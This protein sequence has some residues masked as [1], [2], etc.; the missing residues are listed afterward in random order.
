VIR[1]PVF[2]LALDVVGSA[3]KAGKGGKEQEDLVECVTDVVVQ[4][5]LAFFGEPTGEKVITVS[6]AGL[7]AIGAG[8]WGG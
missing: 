8:G 3:G 1:D 7:F 2:G 4:R 6:V 5:G